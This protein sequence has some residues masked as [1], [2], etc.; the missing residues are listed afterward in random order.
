MIKQPLTFYIEIEDYSAKTW[1]ITKNLI[2]EIC[3]A[4]QGR[5]TDKTFWPDNIKIFATKEL[6]YKK[7]KELSKKE[8]IA[9]LKKI[10]NFGHIDFTIILKLYEFPIDLKKTLYFFLSRRT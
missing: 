9:L 1:C 5:H 6:Y 7:A 3:N 8:Y 2:A 10:A 4:Q